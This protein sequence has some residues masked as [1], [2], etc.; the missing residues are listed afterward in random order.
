M[1]NDGCVGLGMIRG[2]GGMTL[3]ES[4]ETAVIYGMPRE[5]VEA[6]VVDKVLPLG[7]MAHEII[8]ACGGGSGR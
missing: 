4:K 5:A 3:A 6:G 1:G 8:R 7:D 2:M